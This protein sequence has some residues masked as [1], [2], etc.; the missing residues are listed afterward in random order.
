MTKYSIADAKKLRNAV[1]DYYYE[2][3]DQLPQ[4]KQF[5]FASRMYSWSHSPKARK[6][7]TAQKALL[8]ND[9]P[10]KTL[11]DLINN[12][13]SAKVN[14]SELRQ[15]Y[16]EKYPWLRGEMLALF[17]V[18]HLL[19]YYGIDCR[20]DLLDIVAKKELHSKSNQLKKDREATAILSTY[21]INY[22]YLVDSILF[23]G[24][25]NDLTAFA[26][27]VYAMKD[28]FGN[29]KQDMLLLIYLFTH[30]VIG[31]SNFYEKPVEANVYRQMVLYIERLIQ[32]NFTDINLD[33]KFE[34]LVCAKLINY[35]SHLEDKILAE[36][37]SSL[38][39]E[40]I[41]LIDSHNLAKQNNK[42]SFSDSEHRNVLFIMSQTDF[43]K[44]K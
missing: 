4:D 42:T 10:Q 36:A 24:S 35:K 39:P 18:R 22:I 34:F 28:L 21:A 29:S 17:R 41:F 8:I 33:N 2:H 43:V 3:F 1:C 37:V 26:K 5:H 23:P 6:L 9:K 30:C 19:T 7:L 11:N 16:F 15:P 38:S 27:D 31:Q 14:A 40:G 25:S 13:P 12:P 20:D 44:S 32:N